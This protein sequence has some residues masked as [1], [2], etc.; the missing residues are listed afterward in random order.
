MHRLD[1]FSVNSLESSQH[2]AGVKLW[3]VA[4]WCASIKTATYLT[5]HLYIMYVYTCTYKDRKC[6]LHKTKV[7][8]TLTVQFWHFNPSSACLSVLGSRSC[9]AEPGRQHA[10]DTARERVLQSGRLFAWGYHLSQPG[11]L[12]DWATSF[13]V[14]Q[15]A[16]KRWRMYR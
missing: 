3:S 2:E 9:S 13:E 5:S 11:C 10:V 15:K 1:H 14:E 16:D 8:S 7:A 4:N 12:C 6:H